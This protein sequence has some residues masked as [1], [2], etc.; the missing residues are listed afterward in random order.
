MK[1]IKR[2]ERFILETQTE[3]D[4]DFALLKIKDFYSQSQIEKM[5][6]DEVGNWIEDTESREY[7]N[8]MDWYSSHGSG[9]V[10]EIVI[11]QLMDWYEGEYSTELTDSQRVDLSNQ[12]IATYSELQF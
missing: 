5:I 2:Y 7:E 8:P 9:E 11:D 3:F 4:L 1:S 6:R 10:E 12:I